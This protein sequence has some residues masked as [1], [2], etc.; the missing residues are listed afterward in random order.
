M[1]TCFSL[2]LAGISVESFVIFASTLQDTSE[3]TDYM[4]N[5][6]VILFVAICGIVSFLIAVSNLGYSSYIRFYRKMSKIE[7][8]YRET[9]SN[10]SEI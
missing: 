9:A 4:T 10:N 8:L 3:F 1:N 2:V 5:K 7:Y 6:W